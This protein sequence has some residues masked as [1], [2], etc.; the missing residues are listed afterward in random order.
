MFLIAGKYDSLIRRDK[1]AG[2]I[3][4]RMQGTGKWIGIDLSKQTYELRYFNQKGKVGSSGG[5]TT[6]E[7]RVKLYEKLKAIVSRYR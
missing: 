7:G 1:G 4:V 2:F 6:K 3:E 5:K